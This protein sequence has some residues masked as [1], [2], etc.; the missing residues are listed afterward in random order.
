MFQILRMSHWKLEGFNQ[1]SKKRFNLVCSKIFDQK[2]LYDFQL[3]KNWI[4]KAWNV[5]NHEK[6]VL[7]R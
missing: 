7:V 4:K 5:K 2:N 6:A 3:C 1:T